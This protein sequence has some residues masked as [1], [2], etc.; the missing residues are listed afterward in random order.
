METLDQISGLIALSMGLAWASGIN[1]YAA[2]L[3]LG[4]LGATGQMALP[5]NLAIVTQPI[6]PRAAILARLRWADVGADEYAGPP[7]ETAARAYLPLV[8][9]N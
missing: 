7:F 4:L 9:M 6:F 3:T 5:P 8:V 2:I 1:L